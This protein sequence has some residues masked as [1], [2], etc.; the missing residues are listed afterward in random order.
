MSRFTFHLPLDGGTTTS[1]CESSKRALC[2]TRHEVPENRL[3]YFVGF[4]SE[5][6]RGH[7]VGK[8]SVTQILLGRTCMQELDCAYPIHHFGSHFRIVIF[9]YRNR[10]PDTMHNMAAVVKTAA[11]SKFDLSCRPL[12]A[13][14]AF[15]A[16][17]RDATTNIMSEVVWSSVRLVYPAFVSTFHVTTRKL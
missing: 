17:T 9:L 15:M 1:G 4:S 14:R 13:Q 11:T 2:R 3:T 16:N 8:S 10:F 6:R 5:S 12:S 7:V